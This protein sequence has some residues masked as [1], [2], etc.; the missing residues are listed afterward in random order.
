MTYGMTSLT[1]WNNTESGNNSCRWIQHPLSVFFRR[2]S[3]FKFSSWVTLIGVKDPEWKLNY[4][5]AT[6][7][8]ELLMVLKVEHKSRELSS[9]KITEQAGWK[10]DYGQLCGIQCPL[11]GNLSRSGGLLEWTHE[12]HHGWASAGFFFKLWSHMWIQLTV[13]GSLWW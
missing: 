10:D 5:G 12:L 9:C 6:W 1:L 2:R 13:R 3:R 11:R 8:T 4:C 7:A